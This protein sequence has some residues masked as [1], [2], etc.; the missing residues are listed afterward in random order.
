MPGGH[1][2]EQKPS[3]INVYLSSRIDGAIEVLKRS[4]QKED[5]MGQIREKM[6]VAT[7]TPD[8]KKLR[9]A[10]LFENEKKYQ[11]SLKARHASITINPPKL[12]DEK[13][14]S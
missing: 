14:K 2:I 12:L 5:E 1:G 7:V 13:C 4:K 9:L 10:A 3:G 8:P 11:D 6:K